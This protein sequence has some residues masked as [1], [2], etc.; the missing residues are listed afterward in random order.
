MA[1]GAWQAWSSGQLRDLAANRAE[2]PLGERYTLII[3]DCRARSQSL[4]LQVGGDVSPHQASGFR[5]SSRCE[6]LFP[7]GRQLDFPK[8]SS[9]LCPLPCPFLLPTSLD[10]GVH[11]QVSPTSSVRLVW[12]LCLGPRGAPRQW[13]LMGAHFPTEFRGDSLF[14]SAA[15]I[16]AT[17]LG[18]K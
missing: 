8:L 9:R 4:G 7:P 16:L 2:Q 10:S 5:S 17:G 11:G 12:T 14:L 15:C 1:A 13:F 18:F 6:A 3:H